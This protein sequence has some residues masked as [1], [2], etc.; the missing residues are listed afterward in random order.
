[1]DIALVPDFADLSF[2]LAMAGPDLQTDAGLKTAVIVSLFTDR[3]AE[4]DDVIPD[5]TDNRRG[6]WGDLFP[7]D[8][9]PPVK[10]D[11]IGSRL[12]LLSREKQTEVTRQRAI[13]YCREALQWLVD[14]GVAL[15]IAVTAEW[16]GLGQLGLG[17][18]ISRRNQRGQPVNHQFDLVWQQTLAA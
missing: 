16:R 5:G 11:L 9:K 15:G 8:P 12:W 10:P 18:Q 7:A 2:D 3:L 14:D 1:M 4:P 13:G 17:I 6:W